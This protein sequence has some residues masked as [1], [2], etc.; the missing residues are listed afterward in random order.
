MVEENGEDRQ[1]GRVQPE[2]EQGGSI[3]SEINDELNEAAPLKKPTIPVM[4][5]LTEV[6][7]HRRT[8]WPYRTWCKFCN[9]GRGLGEQRG[10]RDQ[11]H[12]VPII[13]VDYF[14]ITVEGFKL[15][16][17]LKHPE[18]E[19]GEKTLL[20]DRLEGRIIKCVLVRCTETRCVFAHVIPCKGSDEDNYV[21]NLVSS[22]V[23]W[24]GHVKLLLKSD[25]EKSLL[26]LIRKV[27][28]EPAQHKP[29]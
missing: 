16:Q 28:L 25:N 17:E 14:F 2:G 11:P 27:L 5:C 19:D 12:A 23:A 9:M 22:D 6:E 4:P 8:H 13:G 10:G 24:L 21:V 26:V 20:A 1:E 18:T 7:E 3:S 15:R 29:A